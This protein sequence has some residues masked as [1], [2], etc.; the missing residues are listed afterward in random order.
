MAVCIEAILKI[1]CFEVGI[2]TS[3]AKKYDK[4]SFDELGIAIL[5]GDKQVKKELY[6][7]GIT[8]ATI[9]A[10]TPLRVDN[11]TFKHSINVNKITPTKKLEH[12][13]AFY[14]FVSGYYYHCTNKK[15]PSWNDT[16]YERLIEIEIKD[17]EERKNLLYGKRC[18]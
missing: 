8:D 7:W 3:L 14:S 10:I 1:A 9:S 17:F 11:N 15:A 12:F 13:K 2:D 18:S 16:E 6:S 5:I 4:K